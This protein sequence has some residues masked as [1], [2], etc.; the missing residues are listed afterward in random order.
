MSK[1]LLLISNNPEDQIFAAEVAITAGLSLKQVSSARAGVTLLQEENITV[2]FIDG[3]SVELY[4]AFETALQ[5]LVGLYSDKVNANTFHFISSEDVEKGSYLLQSPI[6]GHFILRNFQ[7]PKDAGEYYG[8]IV[9]AT[10]TKRAFGLG[11]LLKPGTRIQVI[12]LDNSAKK[13]TAVEVVKTY[14][15]SAQ[16]QSRTASVIAN[17]VDELLM[18]A[19]FDAPIDSIGK[20]VLAGVARSTVFELQGK[21][22]VEL[23][24]GFDGQNIGITAV[25]LF[26]SLD[27]AK[28]LSFFSKI[29]TKDEYRVKT[30]IASAGL[31]L[32]SVFH[33]GG[34]FL[35]A[36]EA[37]VKTEATVF[38]R[39]TD[40]FRAF[41]DQFRFISTQFYFE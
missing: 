37:N 17:A 16:F 24:I 6:F 32:A 5:E 2:T 13:Q 3:S 22:V 12:K 15:I 11:Q 20:P 25:D 1:I 9:K 38:F 29:Y 31:G 19:I 7:N 39:K 36:S 26:G 14:L 35:F 27:K 34:S 23:H 4:Q 21:S 41:K 28:L 33:S 40:N 18:N 8:R 30:A 10:L